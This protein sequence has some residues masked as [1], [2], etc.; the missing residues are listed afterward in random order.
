MVVGGE[1]P[2]RKGGEAID[3]NDGMVG[4]GVISEKGLINAF[5]RAKQS[6]TFV[7]QNQGLTKFPTE[8]CEFASFQIPDED[9]WG[10]EE[11]TRI[12]VAQ[13]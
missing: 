8:L 9:W 12:D 2:K 5:K 13:N 7:V 4:G 3:V 1:I 10:G 6:G 11:L